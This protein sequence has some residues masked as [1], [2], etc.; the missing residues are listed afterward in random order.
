V[1]KLFPAV[2]FAF[3]IGAG[4][5]Q[6]ADIVVRVAPPRVVT[7]HRGRA[8]SRD[9]VWVSGYHRWSGNRYEWEK[10]RWEVPPR[11]HAKWVAPKWNHRRDGYVF[12]E[13]RWR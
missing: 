9:H 1:R 2:L 6:A 13:G 7:E 4:A 10:G 3:V 8:P 12:S 5:V 11:R